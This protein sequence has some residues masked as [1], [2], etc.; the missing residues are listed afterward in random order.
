MHPQ[1]ADLCIRC[2]HC[3][4][5]C[6]QEAI[7]VEGYP[8]EAFSRRQEVALDNEAL[9]ALL[10]QRRACRLYKQEPVPRPLLDTVA[11][12]VATAP[13]AEPDG[14]V[15]VI[16][17]DRPEV[18]RQLSHMLVDTYGALEAAINHPLKRLV[19]RAKVG[20]RQFATLNNFLMP[21]M[22]WY[23]RWLREGQEN[24]L[25][26]DAPALMLFHAPADGPDPEAN[27][28]VAAAFAT[29]M[30]ESLGLGSCINGIVPP[31]CR[32]NPELRA[33][34]DMPAGREVYA[35]LTLG[36]PRYRFRR[37]LHRPLAEVR[38]L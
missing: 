8:P 29:V 34:L 36:S 12:A 6:P 21:A 11:A 38:Y 5:I 26:R 7:Q 22:G 15:G 35:S 27:C 9:L 32:R 16:I 2:G 37:T 18:L 19:V 30:A 31:I 20:K 24:A 3:A 10:A 25:I 28:M 14:V 23:L 13:M 4:A 17:L 1:R 33:L